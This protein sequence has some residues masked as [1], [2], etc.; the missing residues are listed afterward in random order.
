MSFPR[1]TLEKTFFHCGVAGIRKYDFHMHTCTE[2]VDRNEITGRL[3]SFLWGPA[4]CWD[5]CGDKVANLVYH[6]TV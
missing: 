4:H 1:S 6:D 5:P 2:Q 3:N